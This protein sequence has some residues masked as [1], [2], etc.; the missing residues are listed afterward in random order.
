MIEFNGH[1]EY[2][3]NCK[4]ALNRSN[5]K[6]LMDKQLTQIKFYNFNLSFTYFVVYSF[7]KNVKK[8][9]EEIINFDK[10]KI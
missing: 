9:S 7:S 4:Q 10:F 8:G 2:S 1:I 3:L 5:G 6:N